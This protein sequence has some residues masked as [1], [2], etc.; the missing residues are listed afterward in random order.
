MPRGKP[1]PGCGGTGAVD[2]LP[3]VGGGPLPEAVRDSLLEIDGVEG[4]GW[5]GPGT[6][7]VY[8]SA[9]SVRARLPVRIR[10]FQVEAEISGEFELL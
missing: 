5:S 7:R 4:V 10:G 6:V 9:A 1:R 8:V 2:A 3:A